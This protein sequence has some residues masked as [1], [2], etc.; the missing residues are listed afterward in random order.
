MASGGIG[1]A[2][3]TTQTTIV[4][5]D[6]H[7]IVRSALRALLEAESEFDVV[8]EAGD[9]D[10]SVRK[11]AERLYRPAAAVV[12]RRRH[13]SLSLTPSWSLSPQQPECWR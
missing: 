3:D 4:L 6:D 5:A 12:R 8:A 9:V 2:P 10:E 1:T 7:S 11:I 13:S